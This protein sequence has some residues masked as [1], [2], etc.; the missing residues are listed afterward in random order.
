MTD[1]KH[2]NFSWLTKVVLQTSVGYIS[3]DTFFKPSWM[4]QAILKLFNITQG[5]RTKQMAISCFLF[6]GLS[7]IVSC[8]IIQFVKFLFANDIIVI[9]FR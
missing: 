9:F 4:L 3:I 8:I 1:Y 6:E 7:P 5:K 2:V